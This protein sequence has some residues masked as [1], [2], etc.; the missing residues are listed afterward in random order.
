MGTG[1]PATGLGTT[2]LQGLAIRR[3]DRREQTRPCAYSSPRLLEWA[4]SHVWLPAKVEQTK[5]TLSGAVLVSSKYPNNAEF[6]VGFHTFG[7][8]GVYDMLADIFME[9]DN[10][11]ITGWMENEDDEQISPRT[12]IT[13][14]ARTV[15]YI[16]KTAN[17]FRSQ[18]KG[19][20]WN[21]VNYDTSQ[22][23]VRAHAL[24]LTILDYTNDDY[25]D[26]VLRT[27]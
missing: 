16:P 20:T 5:T 24:A 17:L 15:A 4:Y 8:E 26:N 27:E 9:D 18:D 22:N 13:F 23:E 6:N 21:A 25:V 2:D 19:S 3:L 12:S 7:P 1:A 10:Y 11:T 14:S